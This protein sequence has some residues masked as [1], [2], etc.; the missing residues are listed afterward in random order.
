MRLWT[1]DGQ[2]L[3]PVTL[4]EHAIDIALSP[5]GRWVLVVGH[6]GALWRV[7]LRIED[8]IDTVRRIGGRSLT[9]EEERRKKRPDRFECAAPLYQYPLQATG[10]GS[11]GCLSASN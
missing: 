6:S 7:T 11:L 2:P 10:D 9:S 4:P 5:D 3:G 8:W 1:A